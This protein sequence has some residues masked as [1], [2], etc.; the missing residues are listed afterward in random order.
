MHTKKEST[1]EQTEKALQ[2]KFEKCALARR[3]ALLELAEFYARRG[4]LDEVRQVAAIYAAGALD[5]TAR[6]WGFLALGLRM[7]EAERFDL[8]AEF[9][10]QGLEIEPTE[11]EL[12]YWLNNDLGY[13]LNQLGR[14][15][16]AEAACRV[17]IRSDSR[18]H[19]A[20]KNLGVALEGQ[21]RY[22]E[23]ASAYI[24]AVQA[25]PADGR[26]FERLVAMAVAHRDAVSAAIPDY[27]TVCQ[28][29]LGLAEIAAKFAPEPDAA[30]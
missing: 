20:H 13:A 15:A 5:L 19:N 21:G 17:A 7:E 14:F 30:E 24:A 4:R 16:E 12:W 8:A 28:G 10:A 18:P 2:E 9:Y 6:A 3:E 25:G 1:D 22:G 29:L 26:A 27:F 23:A 11:A